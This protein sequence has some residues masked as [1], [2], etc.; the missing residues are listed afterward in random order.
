V[1]FVRAFVER[2]SRPFL[3]LGIR[4]PYSNSPFLHP[5]LSF[6]LPEFECGGSYPRE[7]SLSLSFNKQMQRAADGS[8][9]QLPRCSSSRAERRRRGDGAG[10]GVCAR[11][12]DEPRRQFVKSAATAPYGTYDGQRLVSTRRSRVLTRGDLIRAAAVYLWKWWD[13]FSGN[14]LERAAGNTG[15]SRAL[16]PF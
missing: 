15:G 10:T 5:T 8:D 14:A 12:G 7:P 13:S 16:L 3:F 4:Y 9:S 6:T 11:W 2:G 1:S